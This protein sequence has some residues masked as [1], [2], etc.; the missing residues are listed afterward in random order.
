MLILCTVFV[1]QISLTLVHN[2]TNVT[3]NPLINVLTDA[4]NVPNVTDDILD[5][6]KTATEIYEQ[7]E[8]EIDEELNNED[9]DELNYTDNCTFTHGYVKKN[10]QKIGH[11]LQYILSL[12]QY[13][14]KTQTKKLIPIIFEEKEETCT[15]SNYADAFPNITALHK[16]YTSRIRLFPFYRTNYQDIFDNFFVSSF[17]YDFVANQTVKMSSQ[18]IK[19]ILHR[20]KYNVF[21]NSCTETERQNMLKIIDG[22]CSKLKKQKMQL[23]LYYSTIKSTIDYNYNGT[24]KNIIYI[25]VDELMKTM[26]LAK[27]YIKDVDCNFFVAENAK[28][29]YFEDSDEDSENKE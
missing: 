20:L 19:Y 7:D 25:E 2:T 28:N 15:L 8:N 12:E 27:L 21:Q 3:V 1:L 18:F 24:D 6:I 16:Y 26:Y 22:E 13:E 23:A 29:E 17:L 9:D 4:M 10:L 5:S 14:Q 11:R